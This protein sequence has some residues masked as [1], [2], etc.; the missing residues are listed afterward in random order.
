MDEKWYVIQTRT[1]HEDQVREICDDRLDKRGVNKVFVP[2]IELKKKYHGEW[3]MVKKPMYPGYIFIA[4]DEKT[5]GEE[6]KED[7][8]KIEKAQRGVNATGQTTTDLLFMDLK[9]IPHLT[10]IVGTGRIAVALDESDVNRI[11]TFIGD[12]DLAELSTGIIEGDKVQIFGGALKGKEAL[13]K[14]IDRHK[15]IAKVE[16]ELLGEKRVIEVGLEII[17]KNA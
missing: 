6:R 9:K 5:A 11:R 1:G 10:K 7:F 13:I 2:K 16:T 4:V 17:L 15:R 12:G 3:Q 8:L 14:K